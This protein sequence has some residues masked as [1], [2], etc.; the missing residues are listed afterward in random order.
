MYQN[1]HAFLETSFIL[2]QYLLGLVNIEYDLRH[3]YISL[4]IISAS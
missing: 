4:E 1:H 3:L 2:L